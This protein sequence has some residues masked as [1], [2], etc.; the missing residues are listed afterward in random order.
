V[1]IGGR[2]D[3]LRQVGDE[4]RHQQP[5]AYA[6][7][8]RQADAESRL[9]RQSVEEGAE[10]QGRPGARSRPAPPGS[11]VARIVPAGDRPVDQEVGERTEPNPSPVIPSP[12]V[13]APS[14]ESSKLI[15]LIRAPAPKA[16]TRPTHCFGHSRANA[17][18]APATRDEAASAPHPSAASIS[19]AQPLLSRSMT[20]PPSGPS[21]AA[22]S[23]RRSAAAS[24]AGIRSATESTMRWGR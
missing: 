7:P 1:H 20:S 21:A 8:R 4:D 13:W 2:P 17:R 23:R 10:G 16:R 14:R 5:D 18:N 3:R 15:A 11:P 19:A 12:P 9:L 6:L 22:R 24:T